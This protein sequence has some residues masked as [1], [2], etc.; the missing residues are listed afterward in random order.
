M[1]FRHEIPVRYGEVDMQG[2]VFNA[3][4]LAYCDDAMD[5]WLRTLDVRF[6]QL[7]WDLMLKRTELTWHGG[8]G[9]GDTLVLDLGVR[10]WGTTSFD[11][12]F[13]GTVVE[14]LVFEAVITYV[15]V[16]AGTTEPLA[17]PP[18]VRSLLGEPAGR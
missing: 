16:R 2:V 9:L 8:A 3:H 10:R 7:G 17:P 15:G 12:A 13:V 6:E 11:V 5:R 18:A 1:P 4:Y 14:R